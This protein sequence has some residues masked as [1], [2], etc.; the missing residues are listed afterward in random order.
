MPRRGQIGSSWRGK[1]LWGVGVGENH[2]TKSR[3]VLVWGRVTA[4]PATPGVQPV[5]GEWCGEVTEPPA[6]P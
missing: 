3:L 4:C 2:D 6:P 1:V 5:A